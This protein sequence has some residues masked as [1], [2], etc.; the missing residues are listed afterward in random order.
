MKRNPS[1]LGAT[2]FSLELSENAWKPPESVS[3]ACAHFVK[4]W[5]P[6]C[7]ATTSSPGRSHRWYVL[8]RTTRAPV[9]ATSSIDSAFTEPCVPTGMNV[10]RST[11]PCG[12]RE[13]AAPRLPILA[14]Y[15]EREALCTTLH[16]ARSKSIASP[17]E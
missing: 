3:I 15:T 12:V 17:Y 14:Q 11:S 4:P 16:V 1:S 5:R 10:G 6:P 13:H 2:S 7:S 8:P 9:D